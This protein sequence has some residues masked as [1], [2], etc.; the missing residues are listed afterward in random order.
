VAAD[1][2]S[3]NLHRS[4]ALREEHKGGALEAEQVRLTKVRADKLELELLEKERQLVP[5]DEVKKLW[6]AAVM[7]AKAR[8][9]AIPASK[10][11][12]LALLGEPAEVEE[13][14]TR[15]IDDALA[16]LSRGEVI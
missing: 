8:L 11:P 6:K 2:P 15:A 12:T 5:V 13:V 3:A 10:A 4:E 9:L 16:E 14:L 7:A 1:C